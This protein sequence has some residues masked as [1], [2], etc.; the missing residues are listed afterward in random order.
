MRTVT[1]APHRRPCMATLR[2]QVQG[3]TPL[4]RT[5]CATLRSRSATTQAICRMG[6]KDALFMGCSASAGPMRAPVCSYTRP[7][8]S[9]RKWQVSMEKLLYAFWRDG[10]QCA[11]LTERFRGTVAPQLG[12]LGAE[13]VQFNIADF[14]DLSGALV[15]F[16]LH[17]TQPPPDGIVTFW[18]T[19]AH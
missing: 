10:E 3:P 14:G 1:G 2:K 18:L 7:W 4:I 12:A 13:R 15:N 17:S 8:R 6:P 5:Q 9:A 16:T 19:S 11:A